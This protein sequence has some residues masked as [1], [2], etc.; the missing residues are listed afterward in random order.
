MKRSKRKS[1]A[2]DKTHRVSSNYTKEGG[3]SKYARKRAWCHKHGVWGFE[4]REPKPWK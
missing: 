1:G 2:T 4:V 3:D